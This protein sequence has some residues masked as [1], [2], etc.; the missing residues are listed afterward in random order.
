MN[1]KKVL[2]AGMCCLSVAGA[3]AVP[4]ATG[5]FVELNG[6][7]SYNSIK[8]CFRHDSQ[9]KD[10][11]V[12]M[13]EGT[14][15]AF[16]VGGSVGYGY[17]MA[18]GF[19]V[20]VKAYGLYDHAK[21]EKKEGDIAAWTG[22]VKRTLA[23]AASGSLNYD[24]AYEFEAKPQFSYGASLLLGGKVMPNLLVYVGVGGEATY[25]KVSQ[26]IFGDASSYDFALSNGK[27]AVKTE[28]MD[29]TQC[30]YLTAGNNDEIKTHLFSLVPSVGVK[31]FLSSGV[32][33]GADVAVA[34]GFN[35]KVD[36]K[37]LSKKGEYE[38]TVAA[39][40]NGAPGGKQDF[41]FSKLKNTSYLKK[42]VSV[43]YGLTV[44]YKF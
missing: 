30:L 14:K 24:V 27:G 40:S 28:R 20:G 26:A 3:Q 39:I 7:G 41:D 38:H 32:Y 13:I 42:G 21:I 25:T 11:Q 44:G 19:Y 1:F 12:T 17:E 18:C 33:I 10:S 16:F 35:R 8:E 4:T 9:K 2:L 15:N 22:T 6:G 23:V 29:V 5:F 31:Y 34:I 43:R 37:Y 36:S